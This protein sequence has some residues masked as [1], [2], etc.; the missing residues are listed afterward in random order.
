MFSH[1]ESR[2]AREVIPSA[3]YNQTRS[4]EDTPAWSDVIGGAQVG[5]ERARRTHVDDL[6]R[7]HRQSGLQPGRER[8]LPGGGESALP[9]VLLREAAVLHAGLRCLQARGRRQWRR[10]HAGGRPHAADRRSDRWRQ[11]HRHRR[12][13]S[14]SGRSTPPT[15]RLASWRPRMATRG[16]DGTASSISDASS[17]DS[18]PRA[19]SARSSPTRDS[20]ATTIRSS[21]ATST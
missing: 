13:A 10:E 21:A 4:R 11:S 12:A 15:K 1:L 8:R 17:T 18:D 6:A 2:L 14:R 3:T 9:G 7:R 5:S 19:S 20:Q 16:R